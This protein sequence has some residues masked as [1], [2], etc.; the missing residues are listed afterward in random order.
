[1]KVGD[2]VVLNSLIISLYERGEK[3]AIRAGRAQ[4][5]NKITIKI[6]GIM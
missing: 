3:L 6:N 1:M 4:K 5:V 2:L